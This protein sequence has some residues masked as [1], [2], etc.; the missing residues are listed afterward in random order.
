MIVVSFEIDESIKNLTSPSSVRQAYCC[1]AGLRYL[2]HKSDIII[3]RE[4]PRYFPSPPLGLILPHKFFC[5]VAQP[6]QA[7]R[8]SL[9]QVENLCHQK[10]VE[11]TPSP[12]V[13]NDKPF[14][15]RG[16]GERVLAKEATPHPNPLPSQ[17][18]GGFFRLALSDG[19]ASG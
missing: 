3:L 10:L 16:Q 12:L 17:G 2:S 7:V 5:L 11:S 1:E 4:F 13:G 9:A 18:R 6:F 8:K 15:G 14:G 19:A